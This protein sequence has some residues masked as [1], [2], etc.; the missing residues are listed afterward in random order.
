MLVD[1]YTGALWRN[2]SPDRHRGR[3]AGAPVPARCSGRRAER[4]APGSST[5]STGNLSGAVDAR[6][7]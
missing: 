5:R 4:A 2:L 3:S 7:I 6:G 1:P